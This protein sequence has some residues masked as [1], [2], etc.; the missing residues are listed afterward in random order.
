MKL[1]SWIAENEQSHLPPILIFHGLFGQSDNWMNLA[2][3]WGALREVHALDLRNHGHSPWSEVWDYPHMAED[4]LEYIGDRGLKAVHLV[5]HSMG[6]KVAMQLAAVSPERLTSLSVVDIGPRAYPVHHRVIIDAL[7]KLDLSA[8]KQRKEAEE[9]LEISAW[10]TKQFLLK[11]L[12]RSEAGNYSWR[13]NL[14][15]IDRQIEEVGA[16]LPLEMGYSGACLFVRGALS[17]YIQDRDW[18]RI[19]SQFPRARL[20]EVAGSGH[21]VH[22]EKPDALDEALRAF[23][24]DSEGGS[25]AK[26][27]VDRADQA[28]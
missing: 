20:V 19:Q 13:F 10:S 18:E 17:D 15:V 3:R 27:E 28:E 5:G 12:H 25:S 26:S 16:E 8:I 6:G 22:A 9:R 2:R 1:H 11:N 24:A 23:W 21:W 14:D 7:K 4:V